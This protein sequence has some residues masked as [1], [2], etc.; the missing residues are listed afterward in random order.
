MGQYCAW[1][2]ASEREEHVARADGAK[3]SGIERSVARTASLAPEGASGRGQGGGGGEVDVVGP[4][5][6]ALVDANDLA[7]L[8]VLQK[9]EKGKGRKL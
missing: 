7:E 4:R 5:S 3:L 6:L 9:G 8:L 2:R 1:Q